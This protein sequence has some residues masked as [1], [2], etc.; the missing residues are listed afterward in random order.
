MWKML[1]LS[2]LVDQLSFIVRKKSL[3]SVNYTGQ[4][5]LFSI[6][7]TYNKTSGTVRLSEGVA[8]KEERG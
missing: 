4:M 6:N 8:F 1:L 5:I 7:Y 2:L 3:L